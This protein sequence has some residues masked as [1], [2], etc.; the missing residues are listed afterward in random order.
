VVGKKRDFMLASETEWKEAER[1]EEVIRPL[2]DL[3]TLGAH[4][5][6][7]GLELLGLSRTQFYELVARY[8][9]NPVTSS[10]LPRKRGPDKGTSYLPK[11][12]EAV[13][14]TAIDG[15][16]LTRQKASIVNLSKYIRQECVTA[17]LRPPSMNAIRARVSQVDVKKRV[18]K[19]EGHAVADNKYRPVKTAYDAAQT[20]LDIVQIDHTQADVILVDDIH[21][22]PIG[23]P[24][25]TIAID[26]AS[27][28]V[29]GLY[30][31]L[32]KP[33]AISVAMVIRNIVL[34]KNDWLLGMGIEAPW[35]VSG[36]PECIH[37][38]NAK[39]FHSQALHRGCREYGINLKHRPVGR[40][41]FGGHIERLI[42]TMMG[43]VHL[44]PGTT[45]S[46]I[47]EKGDYD[48]EKRAVMTL[49]EFE[50][51]L[52]MQVVGV[53]HSE[54]HRSL[55]I[56]PID[57]WREL[58]KARKNAVRFPKDETQFLYD[59]LPCEH[60]K[61]RRDGIRLFNIHY[62]DNVLSVWAGRDN[63]P[64]PVK[65]DPRDLSQVYL[66]APDGAYWPIRFRNL[67]RPRITLW[68]HKQAVKLL[69]EKGRR[70]VDEQM[71]FDAVDAQRS[72]ISEAKA[73]TKK[74]RIQ[75]QRTTYALDAAL[76]ETPQAQLESD[77]ENATNEDQSN[78]N[79]LPFDVEDWS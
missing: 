52:T 53:Y 65:Y 26:L 6:E 8:R 58:S 49:L 77:T 15:F 34:P 4:T 43:A 24:W 31:T 38:D 78:L 75:S 18:K 55:S 23:R 44:L 3:P 5:I 56:P 61:V 2:A 72:L 12:I 76:D 22:R 21:R 16:F 19:R 13:I 62:W 48:S 11:D 1:R 41:H 59:F 79:L 17:G 14:S 28:M 60:R 7:T 27:R 71:I 67:L 42:G 45:F 37:V 10:L 51:W 20:I 74:A 40:P 66:Q 35:P 46:N 33:S 54:V 69:R 73:R 39:E 29:A 64:M 32:E 9:E 63:T 57:A 47:V 70:S 25:L 36:L 30:V 68:E 50:T